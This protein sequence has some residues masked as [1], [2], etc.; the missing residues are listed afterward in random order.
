MAYFRDMTDAI[1]DRAAVLGSGRMFVRLLA[2]VF[3]LALLY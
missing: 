3:L 2:G 1:R